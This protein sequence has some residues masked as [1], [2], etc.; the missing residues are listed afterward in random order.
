MHLNIQSYSGRRIHRIF[1]QNQVTFELGRGCLF[2]GK[3]YSHATLIH[4]YIYHLTIQL[5]NISWIYSIATEQ[6]A[7]KNY[8]YRNRAHQIF[9]QRVSNIR[10]EYYKV[11]IFTLLQT[12]ILWYC[13]LDFKQVFQYVRR[14]FGQDATCIY[15]LNLESWH[16]SWPIFL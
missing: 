8:D 2:N 15:R 9:G 16:S 10:T 1:G 6:L 7:P 5:N 3:V 4:S 12:N 13:F 14:I 11:L